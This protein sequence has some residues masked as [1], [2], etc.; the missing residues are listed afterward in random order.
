MAN[1]FT[2]P[3]KT[4]AYLSV[5]YPQNGNGKRTASLTIEDAISGTII[6]ELEIDITQWALALTSLM[7]RPCHIDFRPQSFGKIRECKTEIVPIPE[8]NE[9]FGA[10]DRKARA[11]IAVKPF[12]V[13]GWRAH[14]GDFGNH[15][16]SAGYGKGYRVGFTRFVPATE[17]KYKERLEN[18]KERSQY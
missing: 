13:D 12:E 16:R 6:V 1:K 3:E 5:S 8:G 9:G 10:E 4:P 11:E 18:F 15:H 17:E 2:P 7:S 14:S